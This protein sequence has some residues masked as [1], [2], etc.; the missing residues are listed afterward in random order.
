MKMSL[1]TISII[2][3]SA[4]LLTGIGVYLA[5]AQKP[6]ENAVKGV[7]VQSEPLNADKILEL[8]NA[9]RA[10]VGVAPLVSD[11][12]LVA[13][14]QSRVDDMI[15]RDYY[16]HND[17]VTGESLV[18]IKATNPQCIVASENIN[19]AT[20]NEEAVTEWLKSKPHHDAMLDTRYSLT[21]IAVAKNP[22]AN[23]YY[24]VQHFCQQ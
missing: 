22:K 9:E 24:L 4:L 17:P 20:T 21:G 2:L 3:V 12:G 18:K 19:A 23:W 14:A 8:V 1:R 13:T 16:S 5:Q 6:V 7:Q 10:K 15:A 11:P